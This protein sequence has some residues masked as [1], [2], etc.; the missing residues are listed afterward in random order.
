M[1]T[2]SQVLF[3]C[4]NRGHIPVSAKIRGTE[5][6]PSTCLLPTIIMRPV[7]TDTVIVS[8]LYTSNFY[9]TRNKWP[10]NKI[11]DLNTVWAYDLYNITN[12]MCKHYAIKYFIFLL[13]SHQVQLCIQIVD[14]DY[15]E[16]K[17]LN[18]YCFDTVHTCT[19]HSSVKHWDLV[20]TISSKSS[21]AIIQNNVLPYYSY[22][23][24]CVVILV[25][26][27]PYNPYKYPC[28]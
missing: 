24:T 21:L 9:E 5:V 2:H 25:C 6:P 4:K 3:L 18:M 15:L 28:D 13:A 8:Y 11:K 26:N 20:R 16:W 14:H 27:S 17:Y 12:T 7:C 10:D 22:K 19:G 1:P 23:L